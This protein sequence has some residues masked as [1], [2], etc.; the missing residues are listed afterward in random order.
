[1]FAAER[2]RSGEEAFG[3]G[4]AGTD[5]DVAGWTLF[6][7]AAGVENGEAGSDLGDNSEIVSDEKKSEAELALEAGEEIEDLFLDGDV[8]GGGGLVGNEQ[9]RRAGEGHGNKSA[10]AKAAGKLM[11]E[12]AGA[13]DGLGYGGAFE[14]GKGASADGVAIEMRLVGAD[15]FFDLCADTEDGVERGHWLLE[16]H[17]ECAAAERAKGV[18]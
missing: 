5:E 14:G 11:R 6:D 4:M 10:L 1:L 18:R 16:D 15:G 3:V 13:E 7:D 17:G 8:E 2:R 9:A 12:L